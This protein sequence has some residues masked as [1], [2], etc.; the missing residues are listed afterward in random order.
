ME[1]CRWAIEER[2]CDA[3]SVSGDRP[4]P[5]VHSAHRESEK[6]RDRGATNDDSSDSKLQLSRMEA[7]NLAHGR[8]RRKGMRMNL[9]LEGGQMTFD[10]KKYLIKDI[11]GEESTLPQT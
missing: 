11:N 4:P 5:S 6:V 9:R 10:A 8:K 1:E 7:G 3:S 2:K